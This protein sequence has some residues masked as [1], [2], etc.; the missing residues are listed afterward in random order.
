MSEL[1][2]RLNWY[3]AFDV[4][5][6]TDDKILRISY[7][8]RA[9]NENW[10]WVARLLVTML[11]QAQVVSICCVTSNSLVATSAR[12]DQPCTGSSPRSET[13]SC[14]LH[15]IVVHKQ[16]VQILWPISWASD[17]HRGPGLTGVWDPCKAEHNGHIL[18]RS[19]GCLEKQKSRNYLW[20]LKSPARYDLYE[21]LSRNVGQ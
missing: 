18:E 15:P 6:F 3:S 13:R 10:R 17:G 7:L 16:R 11:Y 14:H 19:L 8:I 9:S 12:R 20:Q 2:F 5:S 1:F 4:H 21:R